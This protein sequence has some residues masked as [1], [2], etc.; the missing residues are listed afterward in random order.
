MPAS[1]LHDTVKKVYKTTIIRVHLKENVYLPFLCE[2]YKQF[3]SENIFIVNP[4]QKCFSFF[5]CMAG[6]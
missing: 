6:F 5:Q 2:I 3:L 1:I 4:M